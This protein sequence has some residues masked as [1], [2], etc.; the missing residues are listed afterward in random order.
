MNGMFNVYGRARRLALYRNIA[1][2]VVCIFIVVFL[3]S[4]LFK[5]EEKKVVVGKYE[6]LRVYFLNRGF[7]CETL[8]E[9]GGNCVSTTEDLKTNFYRY[10]DGFEYIVKSDSYTLSIVHRLEKED[11]ITFK[12]TAE[13]FDGYKNQNF[14]CSFD[15]N[16][17]D[18]VTKCEA[19]KENLVLDV[20][21][22]LG[23]IEQAQADLMN[24]VNSSGYSLDNLLVNYE[25]I[26]K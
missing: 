6:Q 8:E 14:I 21:S 17:L 20:K 12:T 22:Y 16:V 15:K 25:W 3:L 5:E 1:I 19:V 26:K 4:L 18:K 2:V 9:S 7:T 11:T 13:A 24:A 10:K 23:I